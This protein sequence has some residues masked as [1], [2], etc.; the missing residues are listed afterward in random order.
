MA[1]IY[2]HQDNTWITGDDQA[3]DSSEGWDFTGA[4]GTHK[5][6]TFGIKPGNVLEITDRES[7]VDFL[8]NPDATGQA[9]DADG[10]RISITPH[11]PGTF[12]LLTAGP[13]GLFGTSDDIGNFPIR[14]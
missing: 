1:G 5:I 3:S 6:A 14:K 13:D 2:V 4:G 12:I 9:V 8:R 10:N 7:F 11:N